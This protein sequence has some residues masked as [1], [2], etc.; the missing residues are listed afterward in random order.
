MQF[1]AVMQN[2]QWRRL[3]SSGRF[4][5]PGDFRWLKPRLPAFKLDDVEI[6]LIR[7]FGPDTNST[8]SSIRVRGLPLAASR[9]TSLNPAALAQLSSASF[10]KR[11]V[12]RAFHTRPRIVRHA[13]S[14]A[15]FLWTCDPK[16][17]ETAAELL[18]F[19]FSA[20]CNTRPYS[21]VLPR[22]SK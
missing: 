12:R 6:D 14:A 18:Q 16:R 3:H 4:C 19:Q 21:E 20:D 22:I 15:S 2:E 13:S 5:E 9:N 11:A 7:R 8:A 1:F 17:N 10:D